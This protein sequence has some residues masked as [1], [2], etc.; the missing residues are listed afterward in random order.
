M[1]P[2]LRPAS[3]NN[4]PV[5][6]TT[7][8]A[9]VAANNAGKSIRDFIGPERADHIAA[10]V[11]NLRDRGTAATMDHWAPVSMDPE[12]QH[13]TIPVVSPAV[14]EFMLAHRPKKTEDQ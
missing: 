10:A 2:G 7:L 12:A 8:R 14:Q 1:V 11:Q 4:E 5:S 6:E 3:L 9:S 13:M